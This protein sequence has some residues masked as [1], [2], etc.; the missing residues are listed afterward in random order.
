MHGTLD[1]R[2]QSLH[3]N[4]YATGEYNDL[5]FYCTSHCQNDFDEAQTVFSCVNLQFPVFRDV[6]SATVWRWLAHLSSTRIEIRSALNLFV[7]AA[8]FNFASHQ[9]TRS[10]GCVW[11]IRCTAVT[12]LVDNDNARLNKRLTFRNCQ[13]TL[14]SRNCNCN[15]L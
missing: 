2:P 10:T 4:W 5:P 8:V 14:S 1:S 3:V 6:A 9:R 13:F 7:F 11:W 12:F 15:N